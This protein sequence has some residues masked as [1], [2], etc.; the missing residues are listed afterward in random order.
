SLVYS[1]L[2]VLLILV[3]G[4]SVAYIVARRRIPGRELLDTLSTIPLAIP[5]ILVGVGYITF[6][7]IFFSNTI[8]DPFLNPGTLLVFTYTVRRMPFTLRSVFAG[9]QQT[10]VNLEEAAMTQGATRTRTFF[11][12]VIPLIATNVIGGVLL[13]FVY[14]MNEV[15]TSLM[16][17]ALNPSQG[18]ITFLMAQL[19]YG[20]A[21]VG[22]VSITAALG[23]VLMT[24]QITAITISNYVLKQRTAFLGV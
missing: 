19:I 5:G 15:S 8:F 7:G 6:F 1:T 4:A 17:G 3:V 12:I 10:H 22:T 9:L 2:A 20:S 23:V 14:C 16:L 13:S 21:A 24:L 11:S 18:P